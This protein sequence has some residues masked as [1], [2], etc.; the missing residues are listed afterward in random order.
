MAIE[1]V[2]R[3]DFAIY[4]LSILYVRPQE[5][6]KKKRGLNFTHTDRNCERAR[7]REREASH[8]REGAKISHKRQGCMSALLVKYR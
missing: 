5:V 4:S 7:K 2:E 8:R 1:S 6:P 3:R